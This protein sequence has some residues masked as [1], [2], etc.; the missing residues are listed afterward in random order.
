LNHRDVRIWTRGHSRVPSPRYGSPRL[1]IPTNTFHIKQR[2]S[3]ASTFEI[4]SFRRE[5]SKDF[6]ALL[7]ALLRVG[8][9][10]VTA[11]RDVAVA[12]VMRRAA[13]FVAIHDEGVD[14]RLKAWLQG[15]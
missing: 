1:V 9:F 7:S 5:D 15:A 4:L 8:T 12:V 13:S 14:R 3:L 2:I 11:R 6:S 10:R